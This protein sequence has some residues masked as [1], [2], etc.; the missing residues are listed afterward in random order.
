MAVVL[1][2]KIMLETYPC[3]IEPRLAYFS[4]LI[5]IYLYV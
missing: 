5:R 1:M 4:E 2:L 3:C